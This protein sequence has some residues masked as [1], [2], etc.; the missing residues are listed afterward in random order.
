[1]ITEQL[2]PI[3]L[4]LPVFT[5]AGFVFRMCY[6]IA[7]LDEMSIYMVSGALKRLTWPVICALVFAIWTRE[8]HAALVTEGVAMWKLLLPM[9][10][11][12]EAQDRVTSSKARN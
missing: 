7:G 6:A 1:M 8:G 4:R 11:L 10:S 2:L 12:P 3:R 5:V 9:G